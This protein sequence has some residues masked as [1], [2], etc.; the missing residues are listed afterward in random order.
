M[1]IDGVMTAAG[2][3]VRAPDRVEIAGTRCSVVLED[4]E[5]RLIGAEQ[6]THVYDEATVRQ[7][8]FDASI[9]HFCDQVRGGRTVLDVGAGP[10]GGRCG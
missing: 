8:C 6:A 2:H 10:A 9:Q 1:T 5:L 3:A 7:G 4:A